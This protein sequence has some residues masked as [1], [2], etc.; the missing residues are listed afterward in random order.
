MCSIVAAIQLEV[1]VF[2]E[3]VS[4]VGVLFLGRCD[5]DRFPRQ[6][7]SIRPRPRRPPG[8]PRA[9]GHKTDDRV[10][11]SKPH[12][13]VF[14]Q[15]AARRAF[16]LSRVKRGPAAGSDYRA[17]MLAER[18]TLPLKIASIFEGTRYAVVGGVATRMYQP[19][20]VTKDI[21]VL[22]AP[23]D[24]PLVTSRLTDAYGQRRQTL[25]IADSALGLRGEVWA[26]PDVGEVDL[27][28]SDQ[29][30][31]TDA[32]RSTIADDQ[33]L[34]IVGLPYLVV[35]KLDAS[36]SVDQGDLSRMLGFADDCSLDAVRRAVNALLP[37]V[38]EDLESYIEI[39]RLEIG[40]NRDARGPA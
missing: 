16:F 25:M 9:A 19:E 18:G 34:A 27:L 31:V 7:H 2:F 4:F 6:P 10:A 3:Q 39:G 24:L 36:R 22:I 21:D 1:L 29:A 33:G 38:A 28:W 20:R 11:I 40:D 8:L 5:R 12:L 23:V 37:S 35:M 26:V 15:K 14:Q 17:L 13:T 32:I 30:W